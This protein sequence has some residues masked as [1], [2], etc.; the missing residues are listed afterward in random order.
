ML[1]P[2]LCLLLAVETKPCLCLFVEMSVSLLEN[3]KC[4][5]SFTILIFF[6]LELFD[7][8]HHEQA[9]KCNP[10]DLAQLGTGVEGACYYQRTSDAERLRINSTP[11]WKMLENNMHVII[12]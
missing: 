12:S 11:C 5:I 2:S 3:I 1:I 7:A 8:H 4:L 10:I 9:T 6:L